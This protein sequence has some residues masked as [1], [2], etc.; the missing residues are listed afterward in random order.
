M[1]KKIYSHILKLFILLFLIQT[2]NPFK[3]SAQDSTSA[4][5]YTTSISLKV[6]KNNDGTR[7]FT[8]KLTGEG[9][10]GTFPVYQADVCYYNEADGQKKLIG[11][12]KTNQDGIALLTIGNKTVYQ[13]DKEGVI[14]IKVV[15]PGS[16]Q[17]KGSEALLKFKDLNLSL[18]LE[19]K[20]SVRSITINASSFGASDDQIPLKEATVNVYVQG[21]F[22]KLKI[23]DCFIENGQGLFTFPDNIQGDENGNTKIFVRVEEDENF[24]DVEKVEM[25]KWGQHRTGF[26]EPARSLWS[27][28]APLWMIITLTILLVGVW[29][30]YLYAIIQLVKIRKEGMIFDKELNNE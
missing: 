30:H 23:G 2:V 6:T 19:E 21:L 15:F 12:Q 3:L 14:T 25:A 22:T 17:V 13:K 28:G 16:E 11:N 29:S 18:N 27:T 7:T 26:V 20:D 1:N 4:Q 24:G 10:K 9:E 5:G 8:S